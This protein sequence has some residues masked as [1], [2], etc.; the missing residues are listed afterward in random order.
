LMKKSLLVCMSLL[1]AF[2]FIGCKGGKKAPLNISVFTIQ[3]RQQP[4]E[5]NKTYKWIEENSV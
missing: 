4:P 2:S 5:D 3:Q 1:M